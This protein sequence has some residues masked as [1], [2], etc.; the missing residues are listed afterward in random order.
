MILF[1]MVKTLEEESRL[2]GQRIKAA[3]EM[4]MGKPLRGKHFELVDDTGDGPD[5]WHYKIRRSGLLG[6]LPFTTPLVNFGSC[7][8]L[9]VAVVYDPKLF[10]T[11]HGEVGRIS[12]EGLSMR[13]VRVWHASDS[14][15]QF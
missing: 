6:Y 14:Q 3:I 4:Q 2:Y 5:W 10:D 8:S 11:V 13:P 12:S 1:F 7:S 15:L 9:A